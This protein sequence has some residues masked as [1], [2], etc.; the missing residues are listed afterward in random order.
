M[1][2]DVFAMGFKRL[3]P[4]ENCSADDYKY[5]ILNLDQDRK[6]M[7]SLRFKGLDIA[8]PFIEILHYNFVPDFSRDLDIIRKTIRTRYKVFSP[9]LIRIFATPDILSTFP[10]SEDVCCDFRFVAALIED[11]Q[12]LERPANYGKIS[13]NPAKDLKIYSRY[14]E[15]YDQL[16]RE[17][18]NLIHII[19]SESRENFEK[20][21]NAGTLFNI[22]IDDK[23]AG[24][25]G[26]TKNSEKYL[27][28]YEMF[29]IIVAKS[30]RRKGFSHAIQRQ[31]IDILDSDHQETIFG[32]INP[33]QLEIL[34]TALKVG[35]K[36]LGGWYFINL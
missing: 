25:V 7:V 20:V 29:D 33:L 27:H 10:E 24:I 15:L 12:S 1:H 9:K 36:D 35:G 8:Y 4:F 21:R 17:N 16:Y 2:D 30:F 3:C 19:Y 18:P 32:Q 34:N 28:G 11:I 14:L 13:L 22:Y 26:V 23:W 5:Q 6:I 31:L